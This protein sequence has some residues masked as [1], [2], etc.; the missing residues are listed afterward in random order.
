MRK[1]DHTVLVTGGAK[2]LG[3]AAA[4][5]LAD[6]GLNV[7]I[8]YNQSRSDAEKTVSAV[9]KKGVS[10]DLVQA[11]FADAGDVTS[12][13]DRVADRDVDVLVNNAAVFPHGRFRDV[14]ETDWNRTL[15]VNL[16]APFLLTKS[17][18]EQLGDGKEGR[19]IN[20][21]D[22]RTTRPEADHFAYTVSK[23]GLGT[24]TR[25]LAGELAPE[26]TVNAVLPGPMEPPEGRSREDMKH[27]VEEI[28]L[29]RW[30]KPEEFA[31][32]VAFLATGPSYITGAFLH[33]DGGRHL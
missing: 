12:V 23:G 4:L 6:H 11:D 9:E 13:F 7:V 5:E 25:S 22:W 29:E 28:P 17:F 19:V 10:G 24:M 15:D 21:L 8:H 27:V 1:G 31:E 14:D 18:V 20:I 26:V 16:K 30:G 2:R 33:V 32:A 3:R